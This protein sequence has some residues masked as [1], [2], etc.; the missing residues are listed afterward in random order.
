MKRALFASVMWVSVMAGSQAFGAI[1]SFQAIFSGL[2]EVPANA[3]PG[4]GFLECTLDDTTG[5]VNVTL[6]GYDGLVAPSTNAHIHGPGAVGVNAGIV[7]Q[8]I[9][10]FGATSGGLSGSGILTRAGF[11]TQQLIDAML[12]EETYVNVHSTTFPGGEIRGQLRI[13]P[14]PAT[15]MGLL[16]VGTV[17][18]VRRRR[19]A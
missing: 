14:E 5:F 7:L 13:V 8:L 9:G 11:T 10:P 1:H 3:S 4:T 15:A 12:A 17:A 18:L 19:H 6:G 2:E 16:A